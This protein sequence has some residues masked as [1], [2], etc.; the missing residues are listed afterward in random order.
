MRR[1][2]D[3]EIAIPVALVVADLAPHACG[4]NLC[5]ATRQRVESGL[6]ELDQDLLVAQAVEVGEERDF[7]P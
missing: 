4:K 2:M 7:D 5:A 6:A 1:A 3:G